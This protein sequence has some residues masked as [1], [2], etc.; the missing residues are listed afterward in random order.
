VV[1]TYILGQ[2]FDYIE[3]KTI[4]EAIH[5]LGLYGKKARIIA[6]GTDLLIEMKMNKVHPAYLISIA[7]IPALRYLI[8]EKGL[9]IGPLTPFRELERSAAVREKYTALFEAAQS[10][11]SVQIKHMGTVGGNLCH[12][13]PAADSAPPLIAL[14]A[15][16]KVREKDCER[17]FLLEEL[18]AGPG[19]TVLS[20]EE[21]LVEVQVADLPKKTGSAFLKMSRVSADLSKV[22]VAVAI[23]RQGEIC[24]ECKIVLGGVGKT[25]LRTRNAESILT[26]KKL[27]GSLVEKAGIQ[28]SE[29]IQPIDD[30]QLTQH[31]SGLKVRDKFSDCMV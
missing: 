10:V 17:T 5:L 31:G 22:S 4:E 3:P 1:N 7:R 20:A 28:A 24:S 16:V 2:D 23:V 30:M 12:A 14:G 6:G 13:S 29:E 25:P 26:G 19:E 15:N 27:Q 11:S 8:V 21:L 18:F 9:R